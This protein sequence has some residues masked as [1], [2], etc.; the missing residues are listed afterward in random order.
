[1]LLDTPNPRQAAIFQNMEG[2]V[3]VVIHTDRC[4]PQVTEVQLQ[5]KTCA[6]AHGCVGLQFQG[7]DP[8]ACQRNLIGWQRDIGNS[9]KIHI[10]WSS[11]IDVRI[12]LPRLQYHD[13]APRW[14]PSATSFVT[15]AS[16]TL[17]KYSW[18]IIESRVIYST[19]SL[20][21]HGPIVKHS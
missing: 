1:M 20:L 6:P 18:C 16:M 2:M 10:A 19:R 5:V 3:L 13:M 21:P 11:G 4:S 14:P 7:H 9:S 17:T 15:N 12:Q 8:T